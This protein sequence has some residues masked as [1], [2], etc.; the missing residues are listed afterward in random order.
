MGSWKLL[1]PVVISSKPLLSL[2]VSIIL[3]NS[4]SEM[5]GC[6]IWV[7]RSFD[8]FETEKPLVSIHYV[9]W[10]SL[11]LSCTDYCYKDPKD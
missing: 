5:R 6:P 8:G 2:R 4:T 1:K 3:T 7:L 10:K 9:N 11:E